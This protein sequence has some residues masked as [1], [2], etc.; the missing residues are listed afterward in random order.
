[1]IKRFF[2]QTKT[3]Q[4]TYGKFNASKSAHTVLEYISSTT[5][6]EKR[7]K[8]ILLQTAQYGSLPCSTKPRAVK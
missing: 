7:G 1:M 4:N 8:T 5:I 2:K 3:K 6:T